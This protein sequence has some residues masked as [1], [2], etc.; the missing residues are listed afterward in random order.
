MAIYENTC[1]YLSISI[2]STYTNELLIYNG[3]K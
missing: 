1:A 3:Y 2:Q